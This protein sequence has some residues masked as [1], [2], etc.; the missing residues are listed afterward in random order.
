MSNDFDFSDFSQDVEQGHAEQP[1]EQPPSQP[2]IDPEQI[3][4]MQE[5]LAAAEQ[6]QR[7]LQSVVNPQPQLSQEQVQV[8]QYLETM[9]D[10][11]IAPL[12]QAAAQYELDKTRQAFIAENPD[13]ARLLPL[14]EPYAATIQKLLQ[15]HGSGAQISNLQA[16]QRARDFYRQQA[17]GQP[18][19]GQQAV[20]AYKQHAL[21]MQMQPGTQLQQQP[22]GEL[23]GAALEQLV[24]Q[25]R[26]G[27]A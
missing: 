19:A 24:R 22:Q 3:R 2:A 1:Q 26:L 27:K 20:Q 21:N 5:K 16:L 14:L 23:N 25:R 10:Q 13:M 18:N 9:I 8:Q 6:F 17:E 11:R 7:Q 12:H 15:A 4:V